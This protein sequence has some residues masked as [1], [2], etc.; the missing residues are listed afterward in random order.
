M[1]TDEFQEIWKA[2]DRKLERSLQLNLRLLKDVQTQKARSVLGRLIAARVFAIVIGTIYEALLIVALVVVWS[3]PVMAV[4]FAAFI[5]CTGVAIV[6]SARD[7][8]VVRRIS[9]A[10][11]VV[12]TQAKLAGLQSSIIRTLRITWIQLPFWSTFFVSNAL[13]RNGGR[14]FLLIEVAIVIAFSGLAFF[15]Y[16]NITV[17]N[18]NRK[19]WVKAIIRGTGV[20][21]VVRAMEMMKEIG[22]FREEGGM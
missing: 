1:T 2:Y 3:Q 13:L 11:N 4:S 7:I 6:G 14:K 12:D 10:E 5:L 20:R 9:Y 18:V 16:R 19:K 8:A 17:E 15:L 22:E 21:S